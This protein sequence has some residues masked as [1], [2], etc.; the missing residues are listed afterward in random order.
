M[1]LN[2]SKP[3][4]GQNKT[5]EKFFGTGFFCFLKIKTSCPSVLLK[6]KVDFG[7]KMRE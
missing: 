3:L 5:K 7:A 2:N 4:F 6:L 1:F